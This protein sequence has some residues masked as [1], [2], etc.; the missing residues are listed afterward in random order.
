MFTVVYQQSLSIF[1]TF[2]EYICPGPSWRFQRYVQ[3]PHDDRTGKEFYQGNIRPVI[4]QS[5]MNDRPIVKFD[6]INQPTDSALLHIC[7]QV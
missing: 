7:R 5:R 6:G 4:L 1:N 3:I 2:N